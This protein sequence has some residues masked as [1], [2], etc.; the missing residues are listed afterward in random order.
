MNKPKIKQNILLADDVINFQVSL[1]GV[2]GKGKCSTML[3]LD[4]SVRFRCERSKEIILVAM[5]VIRTVQPSCAIQVPGR[6]YPCGIRHIIFRSI[7]D[8]S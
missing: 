6:T 2:N 1:V 5:Q 7:S 3:K 4:C 8:K